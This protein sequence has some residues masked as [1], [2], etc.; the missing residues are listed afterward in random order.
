MFKVNELVST[1][2]RVSI[3]WRMKERGI[4][5]GSLDQ[6]AEEGMKSISG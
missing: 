3:E 5:V 4:D 6:E 1:F 2:V